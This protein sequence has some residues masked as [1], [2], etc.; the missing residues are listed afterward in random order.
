MAAAT[1][2]GGLE[3]KSQSRNGKGWMVGRLTEQNTTMGLEVE[4]EAKR[5]G[6]GRTDRYEI[7]EFMH[8]YLCI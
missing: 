4:N 5:W 2:W 1:L 3:F 7:D 6:D 8:T